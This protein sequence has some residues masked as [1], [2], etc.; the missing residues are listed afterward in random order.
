MF[1]IITQFDFTII[2]QPGKENVVAYFF[3]RLTLPTEKDEMVDDQLLDEHIFGIL[4]F[5][6]WFFDIYSY[7]VAGRFHPNLSS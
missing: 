7:L 6:P 2:D 1:F 4:V 5:S 3:S